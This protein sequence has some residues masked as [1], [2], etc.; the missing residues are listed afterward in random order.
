MTLFGQVNQVANNVC[1]I[2]YRLPLNPNAGDDAPADDG[3]NEWYVEKSTWSS[4]DREGA[5]CK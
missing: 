4:E 2:G 1:P 5:L 3:K